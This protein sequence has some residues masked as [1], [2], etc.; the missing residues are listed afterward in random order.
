L[1]NTFFKFY[2]ADSFIAEFTMLASSPSF[3]C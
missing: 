1:K 2:V 3:V